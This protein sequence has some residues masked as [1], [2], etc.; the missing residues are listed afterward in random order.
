MRKPPTQHLFLRRLLWHWMMGT[1]I[2]IIFAGALLVSRV[3]A[4][5]PF[6]GAGDVAGSVVFLI[7]VGLFFGIGALLTG[8]VFLVGEEIIG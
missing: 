1:T 6:D 8:A 7:A 3:P 5:E 4:L 2:G